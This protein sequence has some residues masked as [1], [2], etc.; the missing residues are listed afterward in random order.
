MKCKKCKKTYSKK[1]YAKMLVECAY[2][3]CGLCEST[4]KVLEKRK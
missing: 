4:A 3:C 2:W 1:D